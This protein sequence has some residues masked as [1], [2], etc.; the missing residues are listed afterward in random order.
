M[1][2]EIKENRESPAGNS[3]LKLFQ[4]CR[5]KWAFKYLLGFKPQE[6]TS[7]LDLGSAIHEAQELFYKGASFTET[8]AKG[9]DILLAHGYEKD[10]DEMKRMKVSLTVWCQQYGT[11]DRKL[12]SVKEVEKEYKLELP[13]GYIMTIRVDSL[14]ETPDGIWIRDTK[15]TKKGASAALRQ[16]MYSPQPVLYYAAL[17]QN[18][19]PSDRERLLG[20][21]TDVI[22]SKVLVA[23]AKAEAIRSPLIQ[24]S[25]QRIADVLLGYADLT[26]QIADSLD[27]YEEGVEDLRSIFPVNYSGCLDYFRECGYYTLCP[28]FKDYFDG[29]KEPPSNITID[30]WLDERTV[31]KT[32]DNIKEY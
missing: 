18:L 27:R 15:T 4:L 22:S 32:F 20:W 24:P 26:D 17:R 29:K 9:R 12:G 13:N 21:R 30:P 8:I 1:T 6:Q 23:G 7:A 28:H 2:E 11:E 14:M 10:S 31:L 5:R 3:Q 25:E 16:Y 19:P